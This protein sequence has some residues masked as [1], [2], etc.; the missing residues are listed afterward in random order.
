LN[1]QDSTWKLLRGRN[2][3]IILNSLLPRVKCEIKR[4]MNVLK[5]KSLDFKGEITDK[6]TVWNTG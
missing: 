6:E 5:R 3:E 2:T 1:K 4:K